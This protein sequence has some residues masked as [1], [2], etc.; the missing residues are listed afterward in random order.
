MWDPDKRETDEEQA[1]RANE[2]LKDIFN[3]DESSIISFT[4]HSGMIGAI[5]R[6]IKHRPFQLETGSIIAVLVKGE[7]T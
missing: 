4:T 7:W 2:F 3:N 5:L 6:A 1:E